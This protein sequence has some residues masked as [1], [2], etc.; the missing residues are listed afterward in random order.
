MSVV[1]FDIGNINCFIA[2]ARAGGIETVD[3]EYSDRCTPAIV[4]FNE[5]QRFVGISAK[6]QMVMNYKNTV[7]QFKRLIGH[8]F[9]EPYVQEELK[10][11]PYKVVRMENGDTGI[12]LQYRNETRTFT[13]E[14]IMAMLLS[15]LKNTAQANLQTKVTDCVISVPSFYTDIQRRSL[16]QSAQVAGLNCLKLMND[17]SAVALCYGLFKT[18]LPAA[19]EKPK[20]VAFVD[21]GHASLQVCV[22]AFNK[23]KIKVLATASDPSLGGRDFDER[24]KVYF[25]EEFKNKYK[26]DA[27]TNPKAWLR[28]GTEVE[29]IKK[30]MSS[31]TISLPLR[32]ECFMNDIDVAAS[33]DRNKFEEM[34]MDL[35]ERLQLP[36]MAAIQ[37]SGLQPDQIHSVEIVG[38]STRIPALKNT[39][40]AIFGKPPSTTLNTD[41]AVSRGC[42]I[43]CAMLSHT[44]RVRDIEVL[45]ATNYPVNISWTSVKP[46]V[47]PGEMEVFKK[48]HVY[49]FTK[50]L[51]FPHRVEPFCFK[52]YYRDDVS[53]PHI[54]RQIGEFIVNADAPV[55]TACEKIKVKVKVRLDKDGCF[56]VSS[57]SMVETLPTPPPEKEKE[58]P[59]ETSGTPPVENGENKEPVNEENKEN[60]E[61]KEEEMKTDEEQ[62]QKPEETKKTESTEK[63]ANDKKEESPKKPEAKKAK[64]LTKSTDLTVSVK[65]VGPTPDE[66][67]VLINTENELQFQKRMER[68]R[69]DAKNTVEEYVYEMQ[70]KICGD[71]EKYI[72]EDDRDEF[73]SVLSK[74]EDWLY[75]EGENESKQVYVD[76][77]AELKKIGNPVV[78]RCHA[79]QNIPAAIESFG[80]SITHYRKILDLYA[81][82]D[83]KYEHI[84]EEEMKKV[85]S[86]LDEKFAWFN[87]KLNENGKCPMTSNPAVY[88]SQI[89]TEKKLLQTFCDPIIN[90]PKPK[91]EPPKDTP[92]EADPTKTEN[93][94]DNNK[95]EQKPDEGAPTTN[96]PDTTA[97]NMETDTPKSTET[98]EPP[99]KELNMEID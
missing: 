8:K 84:E 99:A 74:V 81:K 94:K 23:G 54:D 82:K 98:T 15:E 7:S 51:T 88:P 41:E 49:P 62:K 59:M 80:R 56:T 79:H 45:D 13:P 14:Q 69:S 21:L 87:K 3:N 19:E 10:M 85:Q 42:A 34:S 77:L 36:M 89:E 43:Q 16:L 9:D 32:I 35:L 39:V 50:L 64:K 96:V 1:G 30:Q 90:K 12:Q 70:D 5:V 57:A 11:L 33:V 29:K 53:I 37:D 63:K 48:N 66:I 61:K 6:N 38:A 17:T 92:K 55:D 93:N 22:A 72:S 18:D 24:L 46:G 68:E 67:N 65:Q 95:T 27:R 76:K 60:T 83:E 40:E 31:N 25:A 97:E 4:G 2:V 78:E 86:K 71:Y 75:D 26:I 28:L 73:R 47:D 20:H 44:V 58:E 52:A 91:V